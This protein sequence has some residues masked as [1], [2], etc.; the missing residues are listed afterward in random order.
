VQ[1][2]ERNATNILVVLTAAAW[3]LTA[4]AGYSDQAAFSLGFIPLRVM[5]PAVA[6]AAIPAFL[7]PLTAPFVHSGLVHLGFNLLILL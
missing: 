2:V 3:I 4:L 1:R 6:W 7:T 5:H